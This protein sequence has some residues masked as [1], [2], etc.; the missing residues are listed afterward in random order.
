VAAFAA[1]SCLC[2]DYRVPATMINPIERAVSDVLERQVAAVGEPWLSS[3]D[4]VQL[5]SQLLELGFSS[6]ESPTADEL[7]LRYFARRKDGL[8]TGGGARVM[9][10]NK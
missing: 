6:A 8:C 4:P 9:C 10:A 2:F 7:N 5:Q 1:G 3:F